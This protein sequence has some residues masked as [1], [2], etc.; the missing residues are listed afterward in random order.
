M[1]ME[2]EKEKEK[3]KNSLVARATYRAGIVAGA[4][5]RA[6]LFLPKRVMAQDTFPQKLA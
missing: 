1:E 6:K 4:A 2:K 3:K 5:L